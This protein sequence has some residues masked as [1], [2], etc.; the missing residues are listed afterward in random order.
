MILLDTHVYLW[1]VNGD[2]KLKQ[3]YL[4]FLENEQKKFISV[5]SIWEISLLLKRERLKLNQALEEWIRNST[6]AFKID[7]INLDPDIIYVYH[8]LNNFH[9]DPAD[10]FIAS[11]S[12]NRK[13]PLL[14]FDRKLIDYSGVETLPL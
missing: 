3:N 9:G 4:D 2:L 10:K 14:T 7:V 12:I 11:T 1:L 6:I 13:I 5:I 8:M